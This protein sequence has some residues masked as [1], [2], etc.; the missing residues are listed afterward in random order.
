MKNQFRLL[1]AIAVIF[2][3]TSCE[4]MTVDETEVS[5][6]QSTRVAAEPA[7]TLIFKSEFNSATTAVGFKSGTQDI[8]SGTNDGYNWSIVNPKFDIYY[9][10]PGTN[11]DRKATITTDDAP[12]TSQGILKFSITNAT[13]PDKLNAGA[14]QFKGRVQAQLYGFLNPVVGSS[15]KGQSLK[16]FYQKVQ[17]K[18]H[19]SS[20]NKILQNQTVLVPGTSDWLT[21]FENFNG[22][23][24]FADQ[25]KGYRTGISLAKTTDKLH[26]IVSIG[27]EKNTPTGWSGAAPEGWNQKAN[28]FFIEPGVWYTFETYLREGF[29]GSGGQGRMWVKVTRNDNGSNV[30]LG[31]TTTPVNTQ[32][33]IDATSNGFDKICPLK[34]YTSGNM[35]NAAK[36]N[37][38]QVYYGS[39]ELYNHL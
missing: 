8:L 15:T 25:S 2:T 31:S 10:T 33:S 5:K 29:G 18:L 23:A 34:L 21:L 13:I 12:N 26:F 11:A 7:K 37:P 30:T 6:P 24:D 14:A 27:G 9:D 19:Y 36:P 3:A 28:N 39:W 32:S 4:K 38:M 1:S 22:I 16:E 17:L 35:V 20:F